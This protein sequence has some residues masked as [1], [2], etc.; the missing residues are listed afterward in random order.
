MPRRK[1]GSGWALAVGVSLVLALLFA[2]IGGR[3]FDYSLKAVLILGLSGATIGAMIAP[4]I[5]PKAFR[6]PALWQAACGIGGCVLIAIL[7]ES[8]PAGYGLAVVGGALL[9]LTAS[10]WHKFVDIP[11]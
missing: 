10:W 7:V 3:R 2:L 6:R 1:P 4:E 5:E 9:G 8:G 11:S